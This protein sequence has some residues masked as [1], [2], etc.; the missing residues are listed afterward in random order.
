[1]DNRARFRHRE[2]LFA[3]AREHVS[4]V[5]LFCAHDPQEFAQLAGDPGTISGAL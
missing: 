4:Q 1:M 2:R 5:K 3:V